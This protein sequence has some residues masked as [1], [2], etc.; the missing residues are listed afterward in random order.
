MEKVSN[1]RN[2]DGKVSYVLQEKRQ[3]FDINLVLKILNI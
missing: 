3:T 1:K 2:V